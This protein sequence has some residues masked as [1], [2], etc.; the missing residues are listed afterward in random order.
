MLLPHA[1]DHFLIPAVQK[2]PPL[3]AVGR[4]AGRRIQNIKYGQIRGIVKKTL[5]K[6][7]KP[8]QQMFPYV[9]FGLP[10]G[11]NGEMVFVF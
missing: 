11:K 3:H 2:R 5:A 8:D 7:R 9:L 6:G 4:R 1:L 10:G